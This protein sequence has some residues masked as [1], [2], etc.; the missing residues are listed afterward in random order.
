[1]AD[2]TEEEKMKLRSKKRGY[3]IK[4]L[5]TTEH[6]YLKR[7]Q[8]FFDVVVEPLSKNKLVDQSTMT[9]QFDI[10]EKLCEIHSKF[11]NNLVTSQESGDLNLAELF[12][13]FAD[14]IHYYSEYLSNYEPAMKSRGGLL[15]KN[16]RFAEFI[17]EVE[18]DPR[19]ENQG[20][21]SFLILPVQRIPRY[22]L[23]VEEVRKYTPETHPDYASVNIALERISDIA[24]ANNE[25]IRNRENKNKLMEVM[26]KLDYRYRIN[27]L[28]GNSLFV[29]E[30]SLLRQ[31]R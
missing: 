9:E 7:L 20:I 30:G 13:L 2:T 5:M 8:N 11:Y 19:L 6:T 1:M 23:L 12:Q 25:A 27:L 3:V 4:E 21:E 31:C 29:K 14:N 17:K 22:R 18:Q 24:T 10:I 26:M 28:D 16:R 15:T